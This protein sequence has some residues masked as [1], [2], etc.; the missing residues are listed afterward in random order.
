MTPELIGILGIALL[1][2]L[3]LLKVPVAI[4][5]LIVGF[6]GYSAIRGID[7]GLTQLGSAPFETASS[8]SLSVI[9]LFILMGMLLSYS[10][11][12]KDLFRAVDSWVGHISGGL[13]MATIGTSAIFSSI[14]GSVNATTATMAKITLPE[15]EKYNY[16]PSLSTSAIAAGGTLGVLIPPSVLLILYGVLTGEVIGALLIAGIVPGILQVALFGL[17]IYILVKRDPELAPTRAE[18]ASFLDRIKISKDVIPV[19]IIFLISIGGIYLG[20]FTP[21]EAAAIGAFAAFLFAII[22]RR[23]NLK[24]LLQALDESIRLTAMI[25]LIL[26]GTTLFSQFLSISRIPVKLTSFIGELSVSPYLILTLIL[27]VYLILGMFIEGLSIFV[28]TLPIVYPLIIDLGFSGLW[29][30]IVMVMIVN[31]GLLTPPLG[32]NVFIIKGVANHIPMNS[33]FKGVIPM[34]IAMVISIVIIIIF[35]E[36]VTFLPDLMRD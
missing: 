13:A 5:L 2:V 25:F 12:G 14:S 15:M 23:L 29:F 6:V 3:F 34:I 24:R 35:P 9:P 21:T 16:K 7:I 27:I 31:I 26:I 28:L 18:K 17:T 32:L 22:T 10:G 36:I 30:G 4:G 20:I 8:Y 1:L 33:I 11:L 19:F